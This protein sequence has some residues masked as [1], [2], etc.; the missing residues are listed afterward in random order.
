MSV[1]LNR[2]AGLERPEST[3]LTTTDATTVHTASATGAR[4]IEAISLANVDNSN[5]CIVT[6]RWVDATPTASVFWHGEVAAKDTEIID[7]LPILTQGDGKVRSITAQAASA[8]DIWVTVITSASSK[9][10]PGVG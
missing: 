8:N 4:V 6:L 3:L 5:A 10:A 9:Q 1:T 7:N 2:T